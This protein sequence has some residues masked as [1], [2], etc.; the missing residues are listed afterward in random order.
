MCL[1]LHSLRSKN[2]LNRHQNGKNLVG[3]VVPDYHDS[4]ST[5][6]GHTTQT[7][8]G[9][10]NKE[11]RNW[12]TKKTDTCYTTIRLSGLGDYRHN[13]RRKL[14]RYEQKIKNNRGRESQINRERERIRIGS[15]YN[16]GRLGNS[17]SW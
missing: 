7:E 16:G 8:K 6:Y 3:L 11:I 2:M 10:H 17:K 12:L 15:R 13:I 1:W 9:K 14:G 4:I 5:M